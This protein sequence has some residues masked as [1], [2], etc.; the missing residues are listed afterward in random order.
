[1]IYSPHSPILIITQCS[2]KKSKKEYFPSELRRSILEYLDEEYKRKLILARESQLGGILNTP[3][4]TALSVYN[5]WLYRAINR[6]LISEAFTKGFIDFTIISAGYGFVHGF[7]PI[8]IYDIEMSATMKRFWINAG[9][10]DIISNY[11]NN[12]GAKIV[13]GFFAFKTKYREIFEEIPWPSIVKRTILFSSTCSSIST[14]LM[15]LGEAI[16]TVIEKITHGEQIP[17][18][19]DTRYCIVEA[20]R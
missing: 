16:N 13:L 1:M 6:R 14:I 19:I 10:L 15:S 3:V 5:G 18:T 4:G 20:I 7:E 11:V 17:L 8:G 2:K 9:L 12:I